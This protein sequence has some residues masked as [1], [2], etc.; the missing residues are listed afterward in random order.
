MRLNLLIDD[1]EPLTRG[2]G[3]R[4]KNLMV[5][6]DCLGI[7]YEVCGDD[8]EW[9]IGLQAAKI[10]P[11]L[12]RMPP[13][14][15]VGPNT[16]HEAA[17][18]LDMAKK[19]KNYLVQSDWVADLWRW[20]DPV[21]TKDY[22]FY[23]YPASVD[24]A[25]GYE[26]TYKERKPDTKCLFYTKYQS[27]ENRELA[28]SIYRSRGHSVISITYGS[29]TREQ[30]LDAC[31]RSEYCIYNSCCEKSSNALMEIMAC[32]VPV[33]VVEQKRWIGND[34]FDRCSAAPHFGERCGYIGDFWSKD[35]DM[36]YNGV[37]TKK[38]DPHSF[39]VESYTA[40]IVAEKL[41]EVVKKCHG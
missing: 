11:R 4:A 9:A 36:F 12:D 15:P 6:L 41:V 24:M 37:Q 39:V 30:L 5:G 35:F 14:T 25:D 7:P 16:V 19:F 23:V 18:N 21:M 10:N 17:G 32:G 22:T 33:Y 3:R 27:A 28:E 8:F 31:R 40:E 38:Y 1:K 20:S 26:Q 2:P 34:K 29:Y 13:Y